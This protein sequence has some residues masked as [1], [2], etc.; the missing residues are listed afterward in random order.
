MLVYPKLFGLFGRLLLFAAKLVYL[1]RR[2][3][4]QK[5]CPHSEGFSIEWEITGV[6]IQPRKYYA[7]CPQCKKEFSDASREGIEKQI[8]DCLY[9]KRPNPFRDN[10]SR[11][12]VSGFN[13]GG[14][15]GGHQN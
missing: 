13:H 15:N 6:A 10:K 4:R 5:A 2:A 3:K 1:N 11:A 12:W 8:F 9:L 7:T 14:F